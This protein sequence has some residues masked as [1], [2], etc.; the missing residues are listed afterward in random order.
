MPR[1]KENKREIKASV[2]P[3]DYEKLREFAISLDYTYERDGVTL[4]G[5]SELLGAIAQGE[6]LIYRKVSTTP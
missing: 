2:S 6:L 5:W 1:P 4:P 3:E